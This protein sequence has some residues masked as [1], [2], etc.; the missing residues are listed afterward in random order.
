MM[1]PLELTVVDERTLETV[2]ETS[3]IASQEAGIQHLALADYAIKLTPGGEYRWS[4]ALV[5]N[6]EQRSSDIVAS[7]TIQ[8]VPMSD[9]LRRKLNRAAERERP[10][11]Y[12]AQG[13]FYD[14]LAIISQLIEAQPEDERLRAQR[15]ALMEQAGLPLVAA[16]DS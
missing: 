16:Y 3:V 9:E 5:S 15:A 7:G 14:A 11:I 10:A 12:A 6:P 8:Y 13:I 2:L 4:V 1:S